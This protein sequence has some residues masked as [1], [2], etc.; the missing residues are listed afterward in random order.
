M[1]I[2]Y[3]IA[4]NVFYDVFIHQ[5]ISFDQLLHFYDG[6]SWLKTHL[7]ETYLFLTKSHFG[8]RKLPK[9]DFVMI[10]DKNVTSI[11]NWIKFKN[12]WINII[13]YMTYLNWKYIQHTL[14]K[15]LWKFIG[16]DSLIDIFFV[17]IL[18]R[19]LC[20]SWPLSEIWYFSCVGVMNNTR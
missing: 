17:I 20:R 11:H 1:I 4:N 18:N 6:F 9:Y 14:Y 15:Y 16:V 19:K 7:L 10:S 3:K 8:K 12:Y 5:I 2:W 13:W